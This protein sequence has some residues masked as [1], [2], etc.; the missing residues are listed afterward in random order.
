[1]DWEACKSFWP[2]AAASHFVSSDTHKWHFQDVGEGELIL[3]LHG[4]GGSTHSMA[5]LSDN[6]SRHYRCVSIDLPGQ[7]FTEKASAKGFGLQDMADNIRTFL[8]Q[9]G[10]TPF[11][12]VAHSA[13]AAIAMRMALDSSTL[14]KTKIVSLNGALGNFRG[15]AGIFFPLFAKVLSAN[16]LTSRIFSTLG[17]SKSRVRRIIESTGSSIPDLNLE[18]YHALMSDQAHVEYTLDMMASWS[19]DK[20]L[21]ELPK[22]ENPVLFLVGQ[23]DLAVPPDTSSRIA[24]RMQR[25][26][27]QVEPA[28]GHLAHE[29]SPAVIASAIRAFLN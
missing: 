27:V 11:A 6:L 23:G 9:Q 1:M 17:Q 12:I 13:G 7:G 19:L 26:V 10:L 21:I 28:L 5:D 29:E 4:A 24:K 2:N 22:V 20:L 16:S 3:F 14:Q 15:L 25:A 18:C 8:D